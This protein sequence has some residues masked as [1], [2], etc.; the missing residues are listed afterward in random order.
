MRSKLHKNV[1]FLSKIRVANAVFGNSFKIFTTFHIKN[2]FKAVVK[3]LF[4]KEP[5]D[6]SKAEAYSER[7]LL[8]S[9][10]TNQ[11]TTDHLLT[12][13]QSTD[14]PTQNSPIQR[15]DAKTR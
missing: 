6:K 11:P 3:N 14:R 9:P 2:I 10:T 15:K 4:S 5:F 12:D 13:H 8:T 7:A 1:L